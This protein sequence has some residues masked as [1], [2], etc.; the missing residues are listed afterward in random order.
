M[1]TDELTAQLASVRET[2]NA[3]EAR[4]VH[5]RVP[6]E[7]LEDFKAAVDSIRTSAWALLSAARSPRGDEFVQRFVLRRTS[8]MCRRVVADL[9]SG[10]FA[11]KPAELEELG[12]LAARLVQWTGAKR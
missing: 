2:L 10:R 8:E 11:T 7:G 1:S 5:A 12:G 6:P 4:L 3:I 9:E